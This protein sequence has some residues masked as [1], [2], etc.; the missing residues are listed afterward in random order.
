M[1]PRALCCTTQQN[2]TK[3]KIR[4]VVRHRAEGRK[5]QPNHQPK[6]RPT[7]LEGLPE[8]VRE[9]G[10]PDGG[11]ALAGAGGVAA[12]DHEALDVSVEH[13]AV[14][15]AAGAEGQEVLRRAGHLVAE[16]LALDVAQV[17]VQRHRLPQPSARRRR[18]YGIRIG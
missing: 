6:R 10:A 3:T 13:G 12:L 7:N 18:Q 17:R 11:A 4:F 8:L 2:K 16:H 9:L 14:V 15:V 5:T 1:I